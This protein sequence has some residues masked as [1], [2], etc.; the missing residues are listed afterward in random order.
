MEINTFVTNESIPI[1]NTSSSSIILTI[2][3]TSNTM[4]NNLTSS[5]KKESM[6]S[7]IDQINAYRYTRILARMK[8]CDSNMRLNDIC[9]TYSIDNDTNTM[10]RQL[11]ID[12]LTFEDLFDRLISGKLN[13]FCLKTNS[14]WGNL[15]NNDIQFTMNVIQKYG[16]SFCS[17]EQCHSRLTQFIDTCPTL[18]NRVNIN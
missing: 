5:R 4:N 8:H 1:N 2:L 11:N 7:L 17:L 3:S 12:F 9:E 16:H 13:Q 10:I 18:S 14:C 15:S 6:I